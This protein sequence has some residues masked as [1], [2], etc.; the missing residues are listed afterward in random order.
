MA[1]CAQNQVA[2]GVLHWLENSLKQQTAQLSATPEGAHLVLYDG[3]CGLCHGLVQFTLKRDRRGVFHYASLQSS[4]ARA[5]L[6]PFGS[7]PD[8]LSTFYVLVNYRGSASRQLTKG[9][10]VI[11][12]MDALGWPWRAV[13]PLAVL[14]SVMLDALYDLVA[15]NRY[16]LFGRR[17]HCVIPQPQHRTRFIDAHDAAQSKVPGATLP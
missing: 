11:F 13:R 9:R 12:V 3:V 1:G 4:A 17:D 14:P 6:Q 10:A 16:R 15:R 8:E 7:N 2:P 5:V